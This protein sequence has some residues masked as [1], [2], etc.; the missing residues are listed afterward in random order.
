VE[1]P[2]KGGGEGEVLAVR[3]PGGDGP[4]GLALRIHGAPV[5]ST[6]ERALLFLEP[7]GRGAWRPL[8]LFLGA[9]HEVE[10]G[11]RK[12]AVRDLSEA[13]EIRLA[14]EGNGVSARALPP[15]P[16]KPRDFDAFARWVAAR[17]AGERSPAGYFTDPF[18]LTADPRDGQPLRWFDFDRGASVE[19]R[20][21]ATGQEGVPGGGYAELQAAFKAWNGDPL[22]AVD[23]RYGGTTDSTAGLDRYD[24]L[25][26]VVFN[27]P[28]GFVPPFNCAAGGVLAI[29]GPWYETTALPYG[30]RPYHRIV[31]ADVVVNDGLACF[32]ARASSPRLTL[33]EILA[34][35][36]GHTLGLG[37]SCGGA[38]RPPCEGNPALDQ[39]LMRSF[40]H[41]DGRGARLAADDVAGLRALYGTNLPPPAA[42]GR[43]T[44]TVLSPVEVELD[45]K[46]L[47][48]DESEYRVEVRTIDGQ[49]AD[50]GAVRADSTAAI[51]QG[52]APA[53]GYVFR[54]RAAR[55]G[56]FSGYSNE[57]R[58]TTD[59]VPG[60]CVTDETSLCLAGRFS[61]RVS[62]RLPGGLAR[63]GTVAPIPSGASGTF[64]FFDPANL[65][66]LV[67]I[68]DGCPV[69]GRF[70]LYTGPATH[71]EYVLTV[72]DTRTGK[73]RIY[74]NPQGNQAQAVADPAAFA[75]CP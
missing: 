72:T 12:L 56:I 70:W 17:A 73:V 59:A 64:W 52:L 37:H 23:Y 7:D 21:L 22:T 4:D 62:W 14:P 29:G 45:W 69:N 39:A 71:L 5:F 20:A 15:A 35:E 43:L 2:L 36:L 68:V 1:R 30:G 49:F 46:D 55:S 3:V 41:D 33:A 57:A 50:V 65:E 58:A 27:D 66:L 13:S 44:A 24:D 9:F 74:F 61:A 42:P 10:A 28:T 63:P 60:P 6:G 48:T 18:T 32:F 11:G 26:S 40:I 47:A 38:G 19:W 53:T 31:K 34:H 54:I 16:E 8:H 75:G 25:N 67:K 51:V